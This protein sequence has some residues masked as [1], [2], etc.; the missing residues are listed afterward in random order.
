[1]AGD[2]VG[3]FR[4]DVE[5]DPAFNVALEE[6]VSS[7]AFAAIGL[8]VHREVVDFV[9]AWSISE[10][11]ASAALDER[12]DEFHFS[13]ASLSC[14]RHG[15]ADRVRVIAQHVAQNFVEHFGLDGFLDEVLRAFCRAAR[16][17]S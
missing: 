8:F 12:L 1:M 15:S 9:G 11:T 6:N 13:C 3:D 4:S 5:D 7:D 10:K 14:E 17:F 16:M 2:F